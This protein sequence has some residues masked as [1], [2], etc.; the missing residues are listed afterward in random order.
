MAKVISHGANIGVG[1][2]FQNVLRYAIA[3]DCNLMVNNFSGIYLILSLS[4]L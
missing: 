1:S 3:H 2:S 4:I